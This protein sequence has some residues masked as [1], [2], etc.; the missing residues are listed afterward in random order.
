[1]NHKTPLVSIVITCYNYA[2]YVAE[3]IE[4]A[5]GQKYKNREIIVINDGSTD[6]SKSII[7]KY[8]E[9]VMVVSRA[10]KG[11]VYTRNEGLDRA[12]GKYILFLD[13]DN[14]L[15]ENYVKQ[16]VAYAEHNN[17]DVVY[18]DMQ[19]FGES[20]SLSNFPDYDIELLKTFNYIDINSLIKLTTVEKRRFDD[21]FEKLT[22]EDWD[23]FLGLALS[24]A[25][26]V[27]LHEVT[28]NYRVHKL[29]ISRNVSKASDRK[30]YLEMVN[31]IFTKYAGKYKNFIPNYT[32]FVQGCMKQLRSVRVQN[33]RMRVQNERMRVE[34]ERLKTKNKQLDAEIN[35]VYSSRAFRLSRKLQVAS[36]LLRHPYL[37][38]EVIKKRLKSKVKK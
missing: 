23:F 6:G 31:Y 18:T 21:R 35:R 19:R 22:H 13:A 12:S 26:F 14:T 11:I 34:N 4:S 9:K 32:D 38:T 1:M 7:E 24:G 27:K 37:I 3:A 16:L 30:K 5:L 17:A 33:E 2:D 29:G 25:K 10:N 28:F 15:T 36:N 8:K 20:T